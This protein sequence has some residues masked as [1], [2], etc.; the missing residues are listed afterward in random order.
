M[1]TAEPPQSDA[2]SAPP[3]R[4]TLYVCYDGNWTGDMWHCAAMT[5]LCQSDVKDLITPYPVTII[6]LQAGLKSGAL[7]QSECTKRGYYTF[8]YFRTLGIPILLAR[9][10][11]NKNF[12]LW[13]NDMTIDHVKVMAKCYTDYPTSDCTIVWSNTAEAPT[14]DTPPINPAPT[15]NVANIFPPS[16]PAPAVPTPAQEEDFYDFSPTDNE[17]ASMDPKKFRNAH[18]WTSTTIVMQYL[19][20]STKRAA[21]IGYLQQMFG[22]KNEAAQWYKDAD[23]LVGKLNQLQVATGKNVVLFNYRIGDVNRQHNSNLNLLNFVETQAAAKSLAVISI[24]VGASIAATNALKQQRPGKVLELYAPNVAYDKR[25]TSAFWA[26]VA[27]KCPKVFGLIGGRSGSM[28]IA[29]FMGV[30]C[31]SWDEP[32]FS[33]SYDSIQ[34]TR[35]YKYAYDEQGGQL[36]RLLNQRAIMSVVYVNTTGVNLSAYPRVYSALET[37]GLASWLGRTPGVANDTVGPPKLKLSTLRTGKYSTTY[38]QAMGRMEIAS[39][40]IKATG[41]ATWSI[42]LAA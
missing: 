22:A 8:Q 27:N 17:V 38:N 13:K 3:A 2:Y 14:T 9:I 34:N 31:C 11:P 29:S 5:A 30:N 33:G 21:R 25:Y 1:A 42:D 15:N 28:D 26:I 36:L 23:A 12:W 16:A 24:V 18:L 39:Q 4:P 35:T 20:E 19:H 41:L 6:G 40:K 32:I 10:H 7:V 37:T